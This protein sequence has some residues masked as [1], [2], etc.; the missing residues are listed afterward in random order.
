MVGI[1]GDSEL[2]G[3]AVVSMKIKLQRER[4]RERESVQTLWPKYRRGR[5]TNTLVRLHNPQSPH[6]VECS[7]GLPLTSKYPQGVIPL[8]ANALSLPFV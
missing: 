3:T 5:V 6:T 7:V 4:E 1:H 2:L 8:F